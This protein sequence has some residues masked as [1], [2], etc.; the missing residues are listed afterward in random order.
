MPG[1]T[2]LRLCVAF[3]AVLAPACS[4]GP[5]EPADDHNALDPTRAVPGSEEVTSP[6][7][8]EG[9]PLRASLTRSEDAASGEAFVVEVQAPTASWELQ[10]G[11]VLTEAGVTTVF[12]RLIEPAADEYVAQVVSDLQRSVP[13]EEPP[14]AIVHVRVARGQR[15]VDTLG[16][17]R[18][19][20]VIER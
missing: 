13:L 6:M 2:S 12:L 10:A 16:E 1:V 15:G 4:C 3:L 20:A 7:A 5:D 11:D 18:L 14:A 9:P 17:P 8:Y 19:A